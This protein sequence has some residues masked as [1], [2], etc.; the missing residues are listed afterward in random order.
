MIGIFDSGVGGLTVVKELEKVLPKTSFIYIGDEAR[1]PYGNKSRELLQRYAAEDTQ[2]LV[3]RG[4]R[5]VVIACNTIS[6]LAADWLPQQF[7]SIHFIN[8]IDPVIAEARSVTRNKKIGV[9]G[10][11]GTVASGA[12]ERKLNDDGGN[13]EVHARACPIFSTLAEEGLANSPEAV[14]V[15]HRYLDPLVQTGIDTLIL[16]CT[17]YPLLTSTIQRVVGPTVTLVDPATTTAKAV[18]QYVREHPDSIAGAPTDSQFNFTDITPHLTAL[19][20]EWLGHTV[21]LN[22]VSI[23]A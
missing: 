18:A 20:T 1:T 14:M 8:V 17:H 9:I 2:F 15:A 19:C 13:F 10:T 4:A 23:E 3:A 12:H 7:P 11:R 21:S 16:G 5:V 6:S 22:K